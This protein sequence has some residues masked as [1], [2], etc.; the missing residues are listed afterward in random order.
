M[1]EYKL[2]LGIRVP[3]DDEYPS[4]VDVSEVNENRNSANIVEGFTFKEVSADKY[5]YYT[6][7]NVDADRGWDL[8]CCLTNSLIKENAYGIVAFKGQ[9]PKLSQFT[10]VN[11]ILNILEKHKFELT[12][13]GYLEFGIASYDENS[14]NEVFVTSY[15]YFK[16]W[17]KEKDSLINALINFGLEEVAELQFVDEFPVVS[18]AL[19]DEIAKGSMHY[20]GVLD[21]IEK[22]FS[23]I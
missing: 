16:I 5:N 19:T 9:E 3:R 8:F 7:V 21:Y 2:P 14:L 15:K 4:D 23:Q 11:T 22:E 17:S 6:E 1:I 13:D 10:N 20:S 18:E 12:N